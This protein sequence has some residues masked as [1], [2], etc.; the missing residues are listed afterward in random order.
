MLVDPIKQ[1]N[2]YGAAVAQATRGEILQESS[3][4]SVPVGH[5]LVIT[6][7]GMYGAVTAT[8]GLYKGRKVISEEGTILDATAFASWDLVPS[9]NLVVMGGEALKCWMTDSAA[10]PLGI[11]FAILGKLFAA[12]ELRRR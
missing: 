6:K 9:V 12:D 8:F 5:V 1:I 2:K 10:D 7:L 4:A 11:T 3:W